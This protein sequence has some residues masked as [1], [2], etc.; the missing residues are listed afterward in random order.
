MRRLILL[1]ALS[2]L[3]RKPLPAMQARAIRA[4]LVASL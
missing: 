3:T 4:R 2:R 1:L